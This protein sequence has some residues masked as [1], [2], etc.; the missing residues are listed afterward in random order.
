MGIFK[1]QDC[2]GSGLQFRVYVCSDNTPVKTSFHDFLS[3]VATKQSLTVYLASALLQ[4]YAA[5][6]KTCIV[7]T[8]EGAKS[9]HGDVSNLSSNHE[10]ADTMLILHAVYAAVNNQVV[11]IL[12]P[13][14]DVFV[15][16]S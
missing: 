11:H 3:S 6:E 15:L 4:H 5:S 16:P 14:T 8:S 1:F 9:N 2:K 12:S 7:S 10:E 13:D